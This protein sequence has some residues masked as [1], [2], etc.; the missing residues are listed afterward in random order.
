MKVWVEGKEITLGQNNWVTSGGEADI[1]KIKNKA[2]KIFKDHKDRYLEDRLVFSN[3]W[4]SL[5]VARLESIIRN[6]SGNPIGIVVPW[7]DGEP[8]LMAFN[9]NWRNDH[10]VDFPLT[11]EWTEQIRIIVDGVLKSGA[12]MVDANEWNYIIQ[13][14]CI[15][16]LDTDSWCIPGVH[17][18]AQMPSIKDLHY[19]VESIEA[20]WFAAAVVTFQLW[21]GIHPYKGNIDGFKKGDISERMKKNISVLHADVRVPSVTRDWRNIPKGLL[22]WYIDVFEGGGRMP[23]P[24]KNRWEQ[25]VNISPV[26]VFK[27]IIHG[28]VKKLFVQEGSYKQG[29]VIKNGEVFRHDGIKLNFLT[30][31]IDLVW[32]YS[33]DSYAGIKRHLDVLNIID[34]FNNLQIDNVIGYWV[35]DNILWVKH[36]DSLVA[37]TK[38]TIGSNSYL[39]PRSKWA[40]STQ[41][42]LKSGNIC[43]AYELGGLISWFLIDGYPVVKRLKVF[44][45]SKF[46]RVMQCGKYLTIVHKKN[47]STGQ[48]LSLYDVVSDAVVFESDISDSIFNAT[49]IGRDCLFIVVDDGDVWLWN[50]HSMSKTDG[51]VLLSDNLFSFHQKPFIERNG[52]IFKLSNKT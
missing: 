21:T 37:Y 7:L 6:K 24:S 26:A 2:Y 50:G 48:F 11:G 38:E 17:A 27:N 19:P 29:A 25:G 3:K 12:R 1:Y 4:A 22:S 18:T 9:N 13:K 42:L 31:D 44:D 41:S 33:P 35:I 46:I 40:V 36:I 30:N 23:M 47:S 45:G 15:W 20:D 39:V 10:R 51:D 28:A 34:E 16:A 5:N 32:E 49:L 43:W 52:H 14:G 8:L